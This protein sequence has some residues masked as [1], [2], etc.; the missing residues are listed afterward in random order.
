MGKFNLKKHAEGYIDQVETRLQDQSKSMGIESTDDSGNYEYRLKETRKDPS[1]DETYQKLLEKNRESNSGDEIT[2]AAMN[3]K[4][5]TI[6]DMEVRSDAMENTPLQDYS[7]PQDKKYEKEFVKAEQS[8]K[9]DTEFWDKYVGDQMLGMTTKIID[10]KQPSQLISNYEDRDDFNKNV[11]MAEK[12]QSLK[13]ADAVLFY[14]Y[15]KAYMEDREVNEEEKQIIADVNSGKIRIL[16]ENA[17]PRA[18]PMNIEEEVVGDEEDEKVT[19][20][21]TILNNQKRLSI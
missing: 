9:R 5:K 11:K 18:L 14:I 21:Q 4:D 12:V 6:N 20:R 19:K 1:G 7:I 13:D 3:R 2:E 15:K 8:D 10:N 16:S 17:F